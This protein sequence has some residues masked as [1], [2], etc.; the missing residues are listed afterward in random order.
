M[1]KLLLFFL[2]FFSKFIWRIK[3]D[4]HELENK[5]TQ[6]LKTTKAQQET[7]HTII[8]YD[9]TIARAKRAYL[10]YRKKWKKGGLKKK[11]EN[12]FSDVTTTRDKF[13]EISRN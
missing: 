2:L 1:A 9:Y 13:L 11:K 6:K 8:Q 7:L 10:R 5:L 3:F 12:D 4:G